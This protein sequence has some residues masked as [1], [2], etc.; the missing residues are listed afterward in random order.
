[1]KCG[2]S[3]EPLKFFS[4]IYDIFSDLNWIILENASPQEFITSD[5]PVVWH[6]FIKTEKTR[7]F[8]PYG[9]GLL[10][11]SI[12]V[13][14]PLTNKLIAIGTRRESKNKFSY[15]P[16]NSN[17][18]V[19]KLNRYL[20]ISA[21][22]FIF[23]SQDN[24]SKLVIKHKDVVPRTKFIKIPYKNGTIIGTYIGLGSPHNLPKWG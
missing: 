13:I 7:K 1:M 3:L 19:K 6:D 10:V 4:D 16:L 15:E 18:F 22:D 20:V 24:L 5:N 2:W 8:I 17:S 21:E 14:F 12:E 23:S 11:P 9:H